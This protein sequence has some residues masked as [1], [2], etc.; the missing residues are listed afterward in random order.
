MA[1]TSI[2]LTQSG[3]S[4]SQN[5]ASDD[6]LTITVT[7]ANYTSGDATVTASGACTVSSSTVS[8]ASGT[9]TVSPS[10]TGSYSVTFLKAGVKDDPNNS[11]TVSGTVTT[12]STP[13]APTDITFG[14][15]PGT[16]S[17]TVSITATASG[18][19]NGTMKV[20]ENGSTWVANGSSFT[21][22]RGTAKTIY[23]RTEG[24]SSNS[25]NYSEAHTV[26]YR[27]GNAS[28]SVIAA[29]TSISHDYTGNVTAT[30]SGGNSETRYGIYNASTASGTGNRIGPGNILIGDGS[31]GNNELPPAGS[32]YSYQ[33]RYSLDTNVG[34]D[35]IAR[36]VTGQ[37]FSISRS[38]PPADNTPDAFTFT[39]VTGAALNTVSTSNSITVAGMDSG[40][41]CTVTVSGGTY[42]KNSAAFTSAQ[43]TA[44]NGDTFSVRHTTSSSNST[45]VSTTL[46]MQ[47]N[48]TAVSDT[49][50]TT[51][52]AAPTYTVTAPT[53]ID[54]GSSGTINV[55]T[56]NVSNGT[57]LYWSLTPGADF[58]TS[59]GSVSISGNSASFS[60]TPTADSATEGAET[61]TVRLRTGSQAGTIVA[62]DTFTINDTSTAG[63]GG[64]GGG[65]GGGGAGTSTY[66]IE[67]YSQASTS[68]KVFGTNFR[69][70]NIQYYNSSV[71]VTGNGGTFTI[72]NL[73]SAITD[74]TKTLVVVDAGWYNSQS[75]SGTFAVT[76]SSDNSG[77][78]TITNNRNVTDTVTV[79]IVRIA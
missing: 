55:T 68:K 26:G 67:V 19:T 50:T 75:S 12:S 14:A 53:S 63:S 36:N 2:Q 43:G 66:G 15:D 58:A 7:A 56:T 3:S 77:S 10:G 28:A 54:E 24:S 65:S 79:I 32:T 33:L 41:T 8:V 78:V 21:F 51:T 62:T 64:G 13:T 11:G 20:S 6:T 1:S 57:D 29:P 18:G 39:D 70:S 42:S 9:V 60:V 76:R 17:A 40:Q 46:T 27:S 4:V 34:G 73:G 49:Y 37:T 30:V 22:T 23:A 52:V 31:H 25:S 74:S 69:T 71:Q 44:A 38:S 45:S 47:G 72:T 61:A 35:N 16:A 5:F 48:S 59:T